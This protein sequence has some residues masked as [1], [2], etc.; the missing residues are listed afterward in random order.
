MALVGFGA[1]VVL[2]ACTSGGRQSGQGAD[3]V[4]ICHAT[5]SESNP[6]TENTV[7][8][9]GSVSGHDGHTGDI[10]PPFDYLDNNG[11][12]R[13]Y[14]GKNWD[15]DGQAILNDGCKEGGESGASTAVATTEVATTTPTIPP[16]TQAPSETTTT[17]PS[18]PTTAT[19][20]TQAPSGTTTTEPSGPTTAP[21]V[22]QT[23]TPT[24]A[25]VV[26]NP[27]ASTAPP[28]TG[29]NPPTSTTAGGSTGIGGTG[30]GNQ[31][32]GAGGSGGSGGSA[33]TGNQAGGAGGSAATTDPGAST[34]TGGAP[35]PGTGT[36]TAPLAVVGG[37]TL[38]FGTVAILL[39]RRAVQRR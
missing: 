25:P 6:F 13:H 31:A 21:P 36:D 29:V 33:G 15:A 32:G 28:A 22:T 5:S 34:T 14:P 10:I 20:V 39:G 8:K 1:I 7:A 30:T 2:S 26:T 19:P 18:P 16:I 35:L 23:P 3:K 27:T 11:Q 24:T 9:D 12:T 37:L 17:E 4:T 38:A